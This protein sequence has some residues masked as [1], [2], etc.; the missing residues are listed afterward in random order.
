MITGHEPTS[1]TISWTLLELAK[2]PEIQHRLRAEIRQME[3]KIRVRGDREFTAD[4][5][6]SMP[7][8]V[9]ITKVS[10]FGF[11]CF[12]VQTYTPRKH[13]GVILRRT[14]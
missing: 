1:N 13:Y 12:I 10:V 8:L 6:E 2:R 9:A 3:T 7:Y 5:M 14:I 11:L 4:D